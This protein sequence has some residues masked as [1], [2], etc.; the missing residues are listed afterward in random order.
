MRG[1][2]GGPRQAR[3]AERTS[4]RKPPAAGDT[5]SLARQL[6]SLNLYCKDMVGDGN[7]L[8][9]ALSD[10]HHGTPASH[11]LVRQEICDHMLDHPDD[12]RPFLLEEDEGQCDFDDYVENMRRDG[13][14][15]GNMEL[16]A[17]A[18]RYQTDVC[19]YQQGSVFVIEGGSEGSVAHVAYH[20]YEHYSSVRNCDG[21]HEGRPEVRASGARKEPAEAEQKG[22]Q[23]QQVV[24]DADAEKIVAASTGVANRGL[25]RRLLASHGGDSAHV[26][27]LLVGWMAEDDGGDGGGGGDTPW[28][29]DGG[30][31]DYAGPAAP[32]ES[33]AEEKTAGPAEHAAGAAAQQID[34]IVQCL[35]GSDA[36]AVADID[37]EA[38]VEAEAK[39][40]QPRPKHAKGAARQKKAESKRRQKEMAKLKKRQ[41]AR[42]F[43]SNSA[44]EAASEAGRA[45]PAV[46]L[47]QHMAHIYI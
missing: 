3:R 2:K 1:A 30:P 22:R 7:C 42:A 34:S 11:A 24:V 33:A 25:V 17:F 5:T 46:G 4:G 12:F 9:R 26:I 31:V 20:D 23:Q 32:S 15:G 27:E 41:A 35:E 40:N 8:F 44:R 39:Q 36:D 19:V 21:P 47:A 29:M 13:V 16:V 18:R 45:E 28:F 14:Y 38:D 37:T 6:R 10:Q 43:H